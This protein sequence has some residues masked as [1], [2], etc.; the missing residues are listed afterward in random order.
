MNIEM[1]ELFRTL[2]GLSLVILALFGM[3]GCG[4]HANERV[5]DNTKVVLVT[6]PDALLESCGASQPPAVA[7]YVNG[8]DDDRKRLLVSYTILLQKDIKNCD[9][10]FKQLKQLQDKQKAIYSHQTQSVGKGTIE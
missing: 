3:T 9:D 10:R 6:F 5:V 4:G 1:K 8:T 7:D 2:V